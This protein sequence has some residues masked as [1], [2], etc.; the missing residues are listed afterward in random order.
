MLKFAAIF[1][2]ESRFCHALPKSML[3]STKAVI[4][5]RCTRGFNYFEAFWTTRFCPIAKEVRVG[6]CRNPSQIRFF[7]KPALLSSS[8]GVAF[9]CFHFVI[10]YLFSPQSYK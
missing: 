2:W 8:P 4:Q 5:F 1:T 3:L 6:S 10:L 9:I 7:V